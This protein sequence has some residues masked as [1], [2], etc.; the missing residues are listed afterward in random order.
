MYAVVQAQGRQFKVAE[1]DEIVV[2]KM[3]AEVGS[4]IDFGDVLIVGGDETQVGAPFVEGVRV[5]AEVTGHQR[6][7]KVDIYKYHRRQRYRKSIGFRA[8]QTTLRITSIGAAASDE[9]AAPA[10]S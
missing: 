10:E 5:L 4:N 9:A 1:G 3:D 2:D 6:G 8:G 7:P